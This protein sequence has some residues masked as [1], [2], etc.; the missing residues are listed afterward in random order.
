MIDGGLTGDRQPLFRYRRDH[1]TPPLR[2]WRRCVFV[3]WHGVLCDQP[4]W[5][6]IVANPRHQQRERLA[7]EVDQLF[8]G[9]PALVEAWMR[10]RVDAERVLGTLAPPRDKRCREDFLYR[11]LY[12]DCQRMIARDDLLCALRALPDLTL[13]VLATDNMDCFS[14]GLPRVR[15]LRGAVHAALCSSDLGVLKAEDPRRFFGAWLDEH[16]LRPRDAMLIDDAERNCAGFEEFGGRAI[17]FS[18]VG[19]AVRELQRWASVP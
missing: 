8:G 11:R 17:R 1:A 9:R 3:D 5:H 14:D 16:G 18:D 2:L 15:G 19:Q 12:E 6:S 7:D 4:F 13:V 10:G